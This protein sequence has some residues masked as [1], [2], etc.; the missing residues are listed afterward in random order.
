MCLPHCENPS[1]LLSQGFYSGP[2]EKMKND[3]GLSDET[4]SRDWQ[5][6][7][8]TTRTFNM[9]DLKEKMEY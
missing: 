5:E 1:E 7:R 8:L 9:Q 6:C 3:C 2:P 4:Q